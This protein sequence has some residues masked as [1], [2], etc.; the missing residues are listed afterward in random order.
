MNL[1]IKRVQSYDNKALE[2]IHESMK[3]TLRKIYVPI[4]TNK[5]NCINNIFED[6]II[7]AEVN[8]VAVGTVRI[9]VVNDRLHLIGLGV[10]EDFRNLGIGKAI[11]Q[12]SKKLASEKNLKYLSLYTIK[13]TGNIDLFKK[14]GFKLVHQEKTDAFIGVSC[15]VLHEV[16]MELDIP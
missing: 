12:Y 9:K 11:I 8:D 10:I 4:E 2:K 3:K 6:E 5:T 15:D 16:Y 1:V 14:F 7:I 13:E